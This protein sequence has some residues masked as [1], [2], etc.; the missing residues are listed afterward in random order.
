[1]DGGI[2]NLYLA[3]LIDQFPAWAP[4]LVAY[5]RIITSASTQ[6]PLAA[7]LNYNTQF[8]TLAVSDPTLRW[9]THH[10][11]LWLQCVTSPSSAICWPCSHCGGYKSLPC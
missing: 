1:M 7:W 2:W 9:N 3:V 5:Q 8:V 6:Y 11:D 4:Q 10:T